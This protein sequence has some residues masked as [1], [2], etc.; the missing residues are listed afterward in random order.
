MYNN[1]PYVNDIEFNGTEKSIEIPQCYKLII[2]PSN[3]CEISLN[4][5]KSYKKYLSGSVIPI[6]L[7]TNNC[8]P[9]TKIYIKGEAEGICGV[10]GY[11]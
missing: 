3:D 8:I 1:Y 11:V 9:I 6:E 10:W 2:Q 5:N 7:N 4:N